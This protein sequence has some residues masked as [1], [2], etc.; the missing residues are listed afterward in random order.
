MPKEAHADGL[1]KMQF[2]DGSI[3]DYLQYEDGSRKFFRR[4]KNGPVATGRT[5]PATPPGDSLTGAPKNDPWYDT[6]PRM[7]RPGG[8]PGTMTDPYMPPDTGDILQVGYKKS[9]W[10]R[11]DGALEGL[12]VQNGAIAWDLAHSNLNDQELDDFIGLVTKPR[13]ISA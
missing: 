2:E 3:G 6:L 5:S 8:D 13:E 7:S 9:F 11:L 4:G 12:G 1:R 10:D